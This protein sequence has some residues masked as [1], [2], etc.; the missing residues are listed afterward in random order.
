MDGVY[1]LLPKAE[2]T[3]SLTAVSPETNRSVVFSE[4]GSQKVIVVGHSCADVVSSGQT[5]TT[6]KVWLKTFANEEGARV[7]MWSGRAWSE[8]E[9]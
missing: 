9:E 7:V 3:C 2:L 6:S 1:F 8:L 5:I 4:S